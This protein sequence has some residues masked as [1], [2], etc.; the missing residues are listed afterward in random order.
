MLAHRPWSCGNPHEEPPACDAQVLQ[1]FRIMVVR[2]H[3]HAEWRCATKAYWDT[4]PNTRDWLADYWNEYL[5]RRTKHDW[6]PA[7]GPLFVYLKYETEAQ[8]RFDTNAGLPHPNHE[9]KLWQPWEDMLNATGVFAPFWTPR[10]L[11]DRNI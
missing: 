8:T 2:F 7:Y 9:V 6:G 11:H 5:I 1:Y 10:V 3:S 4:V